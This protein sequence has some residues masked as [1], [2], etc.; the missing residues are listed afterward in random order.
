MLVAVRSKAVVCGCLIAGIAGSN[1][2]DGTG[3]LVV[4]RS[5][6]RNAPLCVCVCGGGGGKSRNVKNEAT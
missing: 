2:T 1:P 6:Q 4:S 3:V 5:V